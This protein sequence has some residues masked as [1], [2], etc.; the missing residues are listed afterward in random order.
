MRKISVIA[1]VTLDGVA[2]GPVQP[3][4][5]LSNGFNFSGWASGY[6]EETMNLV[7]AELM[8]APISFLFGRKTYEMFSAHWPKA[9]SSHGNLFDESPKYVVSSTLERAEWKKTKIISGDAISELK[10]LRA[11]EGPR[12][13]VHG[14]VE[15]IQ[16]L[17][18]NDLIDEFRLLTF[19]VVLGCGKRLFGDGTI[20][21]NLKP[22]DFKTTNNGVVMGIYE[23]ER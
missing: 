17:L 7:N 13:Q 10:R 16:T 6:M 2:Q 22:V 15:F 11:D 14:S 1:F 19:P 23:R 12:L 21:M 4:E 20:P 5:D 9:K 3:D 18:V 8:N